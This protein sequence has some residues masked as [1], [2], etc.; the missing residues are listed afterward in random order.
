MQVLCNNITW[1]VL[2]VFVMYILVG[3]LILSLCTTT[4]LYIHNTCSVYLCSVVHIFILCI[5]ISLYTYTPDILYQLY[6]FYP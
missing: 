4:S 3:G 1:C 2:Y 6:G 5:L